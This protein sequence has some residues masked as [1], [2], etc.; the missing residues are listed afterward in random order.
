MAISA[1]TL[2]RPRIC[3]G[4]IGRR[5]ESGLRIAI[6]RPSNSD[7]LLS[8]N[9]ARGPGRRRSDAFIRRTIVSKSSAYREAVMPERNT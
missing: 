4:A 9:A 3:R 1:V 6:S 7:G 5:L 2:T 8:A